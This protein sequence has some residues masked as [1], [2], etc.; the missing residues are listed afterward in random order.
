MTSKQDFVARWRHKLAG[1]AL[2]GITSECKDGLMTRTSK[3]LE[4]PALVE[5]LLD[6][7]FESLDVTEQPRD[8]DIDEHVD[9]LLMLYVSLPIEK[10]KEIVVKL[11]KALTPA[12]ILN[13]IN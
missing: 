3:M 4:I 13:G 1:L 9:V 11:R 12:A 6:E 10:K 7:M 5:K 2:Y 8:R